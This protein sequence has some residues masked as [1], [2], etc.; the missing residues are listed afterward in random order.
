MISLGASWLDCQSG[1]G[2]WLFSLP[3]AG[4]KDSD[5]LIVHT[6]GV[7]GVGFCFVFVLFVCLFDFIS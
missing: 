5:P 4:E 7:L 3:L 2:W 6:G 1:G